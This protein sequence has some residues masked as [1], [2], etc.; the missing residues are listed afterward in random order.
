MLPM[1]DQE[2][3]GKSS[4][5]T[6]N[7]STFWLYDDRCPADSGP[8]NITRLSCF[9]VKTKLVWFELKKM[10]AMVR[11]VRLDSLN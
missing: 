3:V 6:S 9:N 8:E 5:Q 1:L 7:H 10:I 2:K 4:K 11:L